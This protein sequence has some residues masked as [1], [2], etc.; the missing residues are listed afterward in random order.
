MK[1]AVI[2]EAYVVEGLRNLL[3]GLVFLFLCERYL[4]E[5]IIPVKLGVLRGVGWRLLRV[6]L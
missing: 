3:V 1:V 2:D 4:A 5:V 6:F